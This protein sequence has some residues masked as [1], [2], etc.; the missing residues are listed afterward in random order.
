MLPVYPTN[1]FTTTL[2]IVPP[3]LVKSV[4]LGVPKTKVAVSVAP[5]YGCIWN[6]AGRVQAAAAS[7]LGI[8][9]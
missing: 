9:V 2:P 1:R 5:K 8:R 4:Y 7:V 6:V 3:W